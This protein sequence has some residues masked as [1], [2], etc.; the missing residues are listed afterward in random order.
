MDV[1]GVED[2]TQFVAGQAVESGVVGV[3][4]GAQAG[5]AVGVP[6]EGR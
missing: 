3:E 6:G 2:V 5:A 4:F 1:G